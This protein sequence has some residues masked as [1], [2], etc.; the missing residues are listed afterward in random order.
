MINIQV[1]N[2]TFFSH[3]FLRK[4]FPFPIPP[5]PSSHPAKIREDIRH[6]KDSNNLDKVVVLWTANTER[7]SAVETGINDTKENLLD[8]IAR[9]ESEVFYVNPDKFLGLA[10][11]GGNRFLV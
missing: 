9:G 7:F 2:L 11:V 1:T 6:F 3:R 10:G 4:L 8:S 5:H